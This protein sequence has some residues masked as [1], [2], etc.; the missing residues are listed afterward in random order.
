MN[1]MSLIRR[2]TALSLMVCAVLGA[3]SQQAK[4]SS[5]SAP[6]ASAAATS[7]PAAATKLVVGSDMTFPP[8]EYLDGSEPKGFDI[9]LMNAIAKNMGSEVSYQ[10]TR[11]T[12]LIPG[13]EGGKFNLLISALYMTPERMQKVD[14]IPYFKTD[15]GVIVKAGS[16]YQPKGKADLCGKTI[17]TQKGT[18]FVQQLNTISKETCQAAG[19]GA[20]TVREFET[21]PQATQALLASAVDAQYDDAAVLKGAV[22]KLQG[23][24]A[25]STTE[26]FFP[27]VSGIAV[28]KGDKAT[29]DS[30]SAALQKYKDSGDYAKLLQQYGLK[31]PT[32]ADVDAIK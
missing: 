1:M 20:I 6:A 26:T 23:K 25:L 29:F 12:N 21:S 5:G 24:V 14:M 15:E 18:A 17:G 4:D 13:L 3:C 7:T 10:D 30:I 31:E 32:Q 2:R 11:F 9:E 22:D 8:Y 27:V 19:K 28:K 16:S